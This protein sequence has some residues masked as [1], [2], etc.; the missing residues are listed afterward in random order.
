MFLLTK[1]FVFNR[2]TKTVRE[3]GEDRERGGRGES[4]R[5]VKRE[6]REGER[7]VELEMEGE[8]GEMKVRASGKRDVRER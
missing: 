7:E 8:E 4:A 1:Q 6:E 2:Q 5:T 3:G